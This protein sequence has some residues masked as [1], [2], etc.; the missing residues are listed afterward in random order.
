M[1][2]WNKEQNRA[3][4]KCKQSMHGDHAARPMRP[5]KE[6]H[7]EQKL[8]ATQPARNRARRQHSIQISQ[9]KVKWEDMNLRLGRHRINN[10]FP[11]K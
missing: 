3:Q 1:V 11:V 8:G 2:S 4:K 10:L 5:E 9:G 7:G 6:Q